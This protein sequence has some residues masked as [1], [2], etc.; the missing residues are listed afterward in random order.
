MSDAQCGAGYFCDTKVTE[1]CLP[2]EGKGA[3][4]VEVRNDAGT[5]SMHKAYVF[6]RR[7]CRAALVQTEGRGIPLRETRN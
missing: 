2:T 5:V 6:P 7:C 4:C 1:L 3:P